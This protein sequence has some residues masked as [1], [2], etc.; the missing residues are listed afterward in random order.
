MQYSK[1]NKI[2]L[3]FILGILVVGICGAAQAHP[4]SAPNPTSTAIPEGFISR[5]IQIKYSTELYLSH[6]IKKGSTQGTIDTALANYNTLRWKV[7]AL[8]YQL[9]A[10][11]IIKNSPA[12]MHKLDTWSYE[13]ETASVSHSIQHYVAGLKDIELIFNESIAPQ[14]YP[15]NKRTL[16]LTT[17]V[18]YLLKDSYSI[19]KG[20]SDLK[21]RKVM[22][23]VELLDHAR[24][25]GPGEVVKMGK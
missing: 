6:Q 14:I 22:A 13:K 16:N 4:S 18:F 21:T 2:V 15:T 7:D 24:L 5:L 8:V 17:N 11:M 10:E 9:S 19:V 3:K 20:L 1:N 12:V 23:M 25:M